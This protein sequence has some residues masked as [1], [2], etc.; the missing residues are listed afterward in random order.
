M[1]KGSATTASV[2]FLLVERKHDG[3][4]VAYPTRHIVSF[5]L[6]HHGHW[7][8]HAERIHLRRRGF[9]MDDNGNPILNPRRRKINSEARSRGIVCEQ[10]LGDHA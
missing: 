9:K 4:K 5:C 7:K 10:G 8:H 6:S 3:V 2:N 1:L